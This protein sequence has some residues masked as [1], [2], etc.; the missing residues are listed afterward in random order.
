MSIMSRTFCANLSNSWL[1]EVGLFLMGLN[2]TCIKFCV[3][4]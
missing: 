3:E 1:L 2:D 4:L